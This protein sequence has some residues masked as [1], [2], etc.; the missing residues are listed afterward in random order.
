MRK[1]DRQSKVFEWSGIIIFS[2]VIALII[3]IAV[4]VFDYIEE[5][6]S[7]GAISVVMLVVILTLTAIATTV[8]VIRRKLT[9]INPVNKILDATDKIATGDFSTRVEINSRYGRYSKYDLISSY[10]NILILFLI[11]HSYFA[12]ILPSKFLLYGFIIFSFCRNEACFC[13]IVRFGI[14]CRGDLPQ[15]HF[16]W[17]HESPANLQKQGGFP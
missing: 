2:I 17:A 10:F 12:C 11:M 8:D 15:G 14:I 7:I 3:Q 4:L 16:R 13:K 1:R 6:G 9:I 5:R